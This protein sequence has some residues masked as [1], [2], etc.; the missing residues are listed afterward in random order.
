ME[1]WIPYREE[2]VRLQT[3][4]PHGKERLVMKV[5]CRRICGPVLLC[6][7]LFT[8]CE[9]NPHPEAQSHPAK[10]VVTANGVDFEYVIEGTGRT[11][12]VVGDGSTYV[13]RALSA[14]VRERIRFVFLG[15][16]MTTPEEKVGD[17]SGVTMDTLIDDIEEAREFLGLGRVCVFGFAISG[18]LALEYARAYPQF[19]THVIM[20]GTPPFETART[21]AA[22]PAFWEAHAS[23][24]RTQAWADRRASV[25]ADSLARLSSS[26]AGI[27]A[28]AL[29]APEYFHDPFYDPT[30][31]LEGAY[32]NMGAWDHLFGVVLPKY[33]PGKDPPVTTPVFLALGRDDFAV[34]YTMWDGE[35]DRI[36]NLSYHI[37]D[38]SGHWPMLEERELFDQLLLE[39]IQKEWR[40]GSPR[41]VPRAEPGPDARGDSD[42]SR[43]TTQRAS[44]A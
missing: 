16:R 13:R 38:R 43:C 6:S 31:L 28:Y 40:A 4:E 30:E 1:K 35:R 23:P 22:K 41:G 10:G 3:A 39:W 21:P 11:C 27:L 42:S 20:V 18:I 36:P 12:L 25:T 15:S 37:F 33:E 34:P 32:W 17:I 8:A 9:P 14:R 29:D 5:D 19:A 26:A 2:P 44:V 7:L 24:E